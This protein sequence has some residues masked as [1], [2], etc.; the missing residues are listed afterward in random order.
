MDP[1]SLPSFLSFLSFLSF[2][3]DSTGTTTFLGF[4]ATGFVVFQG[5]KRIHLIKW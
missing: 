3:Q 5:N 4:T 1:P 2:F